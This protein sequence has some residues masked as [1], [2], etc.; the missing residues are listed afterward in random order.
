MVG[1]D[2]QGPSRYSGTILTATFQI[3]RDLGWDYHEK[4]AKQRVMQVQSATEPPKKL[5]L[6]E[7]AIMADGN[8]YVLLR[9]GQGKPVEVIYAKEGSP[10]I[11]AR[12]VL[13]NAPHPNAARLFQNY[14]HTPEAQQFFSDDTRNLPPRQTNRSRA[15]ERSRTS[16]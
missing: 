6:G 15:A 9:E 8:E 5:G 4:L 13:K 12:R 7:R 16:R 2:R 11:R 1:Q 10:L 3:A 14:I